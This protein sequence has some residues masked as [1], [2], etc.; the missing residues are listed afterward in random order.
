MIEATKGERLS[1]F[2]LEGRRAIVTGAARGIGAAIARALA[3]SGVRVAV[4]DLDLPAAESLAAE[5][6]GDALGL[7]IDVRDRHSVEQAMSQAI[8][9]LGGL[10]ILCAN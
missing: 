1:I 9:A 2:D 7:G 10:D 4:A 3:R 6:G 5:I 8:Q